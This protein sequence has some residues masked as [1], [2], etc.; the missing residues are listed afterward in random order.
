MNTNY[1]SP[2]NFTSP[3]PQPSPPFYHP[4]DSNPL[5]SPSPIPKYPSSAHFIP[6]PGQPSSKSHTSKSQNEPI[7]STGNNSGYLK[8]NSEFTPNTAF[9]TNI[10]KTPVDMSKSS[11]HE[12]NK[13]TDSFIPIVN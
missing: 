7:T 6:L 11:F 8:P 3:H 9:S 10:P 4:K 1:S 13:N 12:G 5:F 2:R